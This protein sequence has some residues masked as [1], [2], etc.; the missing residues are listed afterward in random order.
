M[1]GGGGGGSGGGGGGSGGVRARGGLGVLPV[2]GNVW[3]RCVMINGHFASARG[4]LP[5]P[6]PRG[7]IRVLICLC[8]RRVS[9]HFIQ[10]LV[11]GTWRNGVL[12][13]TRDCER[14]S[15]VMLAS[16]MCARFSTGGKE[17]VS[18]LTLSKTCEEYEWLPTTRWGH[19]AQKSDLEIGSLV[20]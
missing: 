3:C 2:L 6:R 10:V 19:Y 15:A 8:L 11:A 13:V 4:L 5:C 7:R 12:L 14:P 9:F 18:S 17:F 1:R 20:K 16:A